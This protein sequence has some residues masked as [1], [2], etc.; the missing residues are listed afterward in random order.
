VTVV[1]GLV[2]VAG[3]VV[4]A[5]GQF[6]TARKLAELEESTPGALGGM[7]GLPVGGGQDP[8]G[9]PAAEGGI[10]ITGEALPSGIEVP[11][12]FRALVG[13]NLPE[14]AYRVGDV[15]VAAAIVRMEGT[16]LALSPDS[17]TAG[18][19][20]FEKHMAQRFEPGEAQAR[21]GIEAALMELLN[22]PQR[23]YLY[24]NLTT[25]KSENVQPEVILEQL[26]TAVS[27]RG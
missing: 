20:L 15:E 23:E 4:L 5:L 16:D 8:D 26:R 24:K 27:V 25:I 6:R 3:L 10:P 1:A 9:A 22:D 12:E 2:I 14:V 21:L 11:A 7:G 19:E 18:L 17:L 13:E